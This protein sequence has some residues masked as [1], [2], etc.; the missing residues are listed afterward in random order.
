MALLARLFAPWGVTHSTMTGLVDVSVLEADF[1]AS[2]EAV[3]RQGDHVRALKA[4]M[5][6]GKVDRVSPLARA[7]AM[8][9]CCR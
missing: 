3:A 8:P 6:Y 9:P 1:H 4:E 2:Q 7:R 5:K